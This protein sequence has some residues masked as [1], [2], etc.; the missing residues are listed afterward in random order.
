M[1]VLAFVVSLFSLLVAS[2]AALY[3]RRQAK[4]AEETLRIESDRRGEEVTRSEA[5]KVRVQ[6][7]RPMV[8]A[9]GNPAGPKGWGGEFGL[10]VRNDG[11]AAAVNLI[12][13]AARAG[14]GND[15]EFWGTP[16]PHNLQPGG[17]VMWRAHVSGSSAR[18]LKC[19]VTWSDE[20]GEHSAQQDVAL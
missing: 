12:V 10:L 15:W 20:V 18:K 6:S 13:D 4:A 11:Q 5:E 3:T 7:A 14:N 1:D 17:S 9:H 19:T 16:W 2:L 8:T